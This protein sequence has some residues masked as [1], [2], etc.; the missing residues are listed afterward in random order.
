MPR[1]K[2]DNVQARDEMQENVFV[3]SG[4][5]W[6]SLALPKSAVKRVRRSERKQED[7]LQALTKCMNWVNAILENEPPFDLYHE[8]H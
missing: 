5:V 7:I 6:V 3:V 8:D 2:T 4:E 1:K